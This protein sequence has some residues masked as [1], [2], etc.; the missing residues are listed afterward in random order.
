MSCNNRKPLRSAAFW[1][2][3]ALGLLV[4]SGSASSASSTGA[5]RLT[6]APRGAP[7]PAR[8]VGSYQAHFTAADSQTSGTW[9][10]RVGPGH[11]LKVWNR[12]DAVD[13]NPSFEA[14]PVSFRGGH[15][16]FARVTAEGICAIGAT[17]AWTRHGRLLRF[18]P[19]GHDLCEP[20]LATFSTHPWRRVS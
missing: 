10:L 6:G 4:A 19:I 1:A 9:H 14:G 7:A 5:H 8:L 12:M 17:Y 11:H 20:R 15:M 3:L 18:R 13:D 16:V 2:V